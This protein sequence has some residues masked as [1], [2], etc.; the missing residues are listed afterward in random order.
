M[1]SPSPARVA[2][3][4]T[5]PYETFRGGED[6]YVAA[7]RAH[8]VQRGHCVDTLIS[9]TARG[10]SNPLLHLPAE[11]STAGNLQ[12]R[13]TLR[14]GSTRHVSLDPSLLWR[15]AGAAIGRRSKTSDLHG[16]GERRWML[17]AIE[18][19]RYDAVILMWDASRHAGEVSAI[20]ERVLALKGFCANQRLVLGQT[21]DI[22]IPA[23]VVAD[24]TEAR[25]IGMNNAA[26]ASELRRCLPGNTV[27]HVG[28]GFAERPALGLSDEPIVLFVGANSGANR[29]SLEWLL[30]AVWPRV[31][32]A[33]P[34]ARLRVAG[35][36]KNGWTRD[37]PTGVDL[38]GRVD[39][40]D[41]EYRRA[42]VVVAPITVGS[43]GVKI[44]VAEALSYHRPLVSTSVGVDPGNAGQFAEAVA[45][46][47]EP[48]P[49]A[50]AV[51]ELLADPSLRMRRVRQSADAFQANFSGTAA[52]GALYEHLAL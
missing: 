1:K 12:V 39:S 19:G 8:L 45:I 38:L 28:M 16:G 3:V 41:E 18:R 2:L 4:M 50:D 34:K 51:S 49:F 44:K 35:S 40:L 52:Y 29:R 5:Y 36:V 15:S 23:A 31:A 43:A 22:A 9:D 11:L 42:Q 47:D 27:I 13:R 17:N 32:A 10:R 37:V 21:P 20:S 7:L 30:D 24:L 6:S 14:L 26:E 33:H 25:L 46:A 48:E